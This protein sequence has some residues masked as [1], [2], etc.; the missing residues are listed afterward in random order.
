MKKSISN[1]IKGLLIGIAI[2][3]I[4]ISPIAGADDNNNWTMFQEN[5]QHTGFMQE[6]GD[7]VSNLWTQN[8]GNPVKASPVI[9][10]KII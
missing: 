1:K 3:G 10:D 5:I 7:F 9:Q 6:A 4:F 8:M 2:L